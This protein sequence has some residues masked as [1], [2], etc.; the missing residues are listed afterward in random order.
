MTTTTGE[1]IVTISYLQCYSYNTTLANLDQLNNTKNGLK[2]TDL[3]LFCL[4]VFD[5]ILLY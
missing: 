4:S 2:L 1:Y 5:T 3:N